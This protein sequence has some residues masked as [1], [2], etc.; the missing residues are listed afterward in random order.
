MT[1]DKLFAKLGTE[2]EVN[3]IKTMALQ[4]ARRAQ[5]TASNTTFSSTTATASVN[6]PNKSA[7]TETRSAR[8]QNSRKHAQHDVDVDTD[9]DADADAATDGPENVAKSTAEQTAPS[10]PLLVRR[11][12]LTK[13]PGEGLGLTIK[14]GVSASV[15]QGSRS[16]VLVVNVCYLFF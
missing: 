1:S 15:S 8:R 6:N 5:H 12:E 9:A 7:E 13:T 2:M 3:S 16:H 14:G 11:V 10:P 4:R